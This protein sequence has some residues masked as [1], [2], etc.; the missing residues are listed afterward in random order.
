[1]SPP[2]KHLRGTELSAYASSIDAADQWGN[3]AK[4]LAKYGTIEDF[5]RFVERDPKPAE[6]CLEVFASHPE[7]ALDWLAQYLQNSKSD[8]DPKAR[9]R[10]QYTVAKFVCEHTSA[11]GDTAHA[12]FEHI[13][14][15]SMERTHKVQ[16]FKPLVYSGMHNI[17]E[18]NWEMYQP[19]MENLMPQ[20]LTQHVMFSAHFGWNLH[21]RINW[22]ASY[23]KHS[24][25]LFVACC[26]GGLLSAA[27]RFYIA[28]KKF[29]VIL[30]AFF[31]TANPTH[32][33]RAANCGEVLNYLWDTYPNIP[34][35]SSLDI[36]H[37]FGVSSV[38]DKKMA[39]HF[40]KT[41][42]YALKQHASL[43]ANKAI[44]EN[45]LALFNVIFPHV[46]SDDKTEVVRCALIYRKKTVVKSL[47]ALPDGDMLFHATLKDPAVNT[48][49]KAWAEQYYA[50]LQRSALKKSIKTTATS[51]PKRKM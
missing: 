11:F 50:T 31:K 41:S 30:E 48:E 23:Y 26:V 7:A 20:D 24:E 22:H 25:E 39:A 8:P 19:L 12:I 6:K 14:L 21:E 37:V 29:P 15:S 32:K 33:E 4:H 38:L 43:L 13:D 51:T 42:P 17:I 5:H 46:P 28:E 49:T 44:G 27:Q 45:N 10:A 18:K 9:S 35:A 1:M 47:L 36:W 3:F 34:W 2:W 40:K 16:L